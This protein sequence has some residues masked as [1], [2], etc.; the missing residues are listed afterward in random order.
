[1]W[2]G[3]RVREIPIESEVGEGLSVDGNEA[4]RWSK[5]GVTENCIRFCY[6]LMVTEG[7]SGLIVI[8]TWQLTLNLATKKPPRARVLQQPEPPTRMKALET[9]N[10]LV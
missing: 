2:L 1:M 5:V 6:I 9:L 10:S 3:S 4:E 8:E 7:C